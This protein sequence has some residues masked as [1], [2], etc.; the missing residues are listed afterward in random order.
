MKLS[1]RFAAAFVFSTLVCA[2]PAARAALTVSGLRVENLA[3][4]LGIDTAQPRLGWKFTSDIRADTQTAYQ[5]LVASTAENLASD[6]GDIWDSGR[7]TSGASQFVPYAGRPLA[8]S[9]Q[10]FWKVRVY[11]ASGQSSLWSQPATWTMGVLGDKKNP[12][13]QPA[14]RWITDADLL[15]RARKALGYSSEVTTDENEK[16]WLTIDL[17][18][19]QK[20]DLVRLYAVRHTVNERLGYP[21]RF[22]VELANNPGMLGAT[23]L[24]DFTKEDYNVWLTKTDIPAP[25]GGATGRYLRITATKLRS[26]DDFAC[27]AL[28]QVAV[29]SEGKNIAVGAKV[30]FLDSRES[31]LWSSA[32]VVDGL[33]V[34]GANPRANDAILLRR[35]F[36]VKPGLRRATLHLAGLGHYELSVNGARASERLLT[37]GWTEPAQTILYDTHDLTAR[38]QPG[39]NAIG[40]TLA[41]GMYNVQ[42]SKGRYTKFAS[43]F[44]PLT[45]FGQL[46]LEYENG[47]VEYVVTDTNWKIG[48]GPITF[49]NVYGGEDYDARLESA[50]WDKPGFDDSSWKPAAETKSPGGDLLGATHGSPAFATFETFKPASVKEIRPGVLIYD[51]GQNVA[52]MPR[53]KVRGPA[54]SVVRIT[55]S[56]LLKA[57]GSLDR[58]SSAHGAVP[59]YWQY[60][61]RGEADGEDYFPHFFYHGARYVQVELIAPELPAGTSNTAP[62][63]HPQILSLESVVTHSD[64]APAGDFATSSDLIN[65]IRQLVRWAQASNLAHVLTDCPHRERLGWLEQYHLNGPSLRYEWDLTQLYTKTFRDMADAQTLRG[66]VPSI[67]PEYIKFEGGFRDSPEWGGSV[68]LAAWQ[69]YIFTGDDTP[70]NENYDV[71]KRYVSYLGSQ[72]KGRI[73]SHG[74]GDWYDQGP[75]RP[76]NAQLTPVPFVA[77]AIY[78]EINRTLGLIAEHLGKTKDAT[79]YAA[80]AKAIGDAF[81]KKFFNATKQTYATS[82]QTSLA[83]PLVLD[84]VPAESRD[85]VLNALV[86]EIQGR[87][88]AVTAGDVGY[89]YVL[90]ALADAGRSDVIYAMTSQSEKPGYAYQLAKGA[91]SLVEAWDANSHASQN[92]FMLGQIVEWFYHDLAGIQPDA[93]SPGFKRFAIKPA[94]VEGLS[95]VSAKHD[96]PYGRIETKWKHDRGTL[97]L[98][99]AVPAGTDAEV[100][101]PLPDGD[102]AA[103]KADGQPVSQLTDIKH[104]RTV[105]GTAVFEVGSGRYSFSAPLK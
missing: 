35:E 37:P 94:F 87:G 51:F 25:E 11:D 53:L 5:I 67:S 96:T 18:K 91:T 54:S 38:L 47:S 88:Y 79:F 36:T 7:V 40:L 44:R 104:L 30:I 8:S 89:R 55:P 9:Q 92:H 64:S 65:R 84:L 70:L 32:S 75:N 46:R 98:D 16:K 97:Q 23:I 45:A 72:A 22:K 26:F 74:L 103:I 60:T 101:L 3:D 71:M 33:G 31:A 77:T 105:N 69:H 43:A 50:G 59:A 93:A 85:T 1:A 17:G 20:V 63:A 95:W 10:A 12:G 52:M 29:F 2:L 73:L 68:V 28:S 41:G 34:P 90:R 99:V 13:W 66:L 39:A 14:A 80:E 82:S 86:A 100:Y 83:L 102:L 24:G 78:F 49:S 57:D 4:P 6:K 62:P 15:T 81:N 76:G 48:Q 58:G 27:F 21:R 56:E 61:L 42:E 19:N